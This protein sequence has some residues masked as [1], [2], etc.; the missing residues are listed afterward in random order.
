MKKG[1]SI[2]Y[3]AFRDEV[4]WW[5]GVVGIFSLALVPLTWFYYLFRDTPIKGF[6]ARPFLASDVEVLNGVITPLR[7]ICFLLTLALLSY[8][9]LA[10][11]LKTN[12][13]AADKLSW[14]RVLQPVLSFLLL[15]LL[16][17]PGPISG[18]ANEYAN[19]SAV[20]FTRTTT[21]NLL[22]RFLMPSLA[23]IL[24]F[25]GNFWFSVFSF[26]CTLLLVLMVWLWFQRNQVPLPWWQLLSLET[27]SFI[28]FQIWSPGYPDVLV[29]LFVVAAFTFNLDGRAKAS[30]FA[31]SL[32]THEFSLIL[33][34]GL[35]WILFSGKEYL[36]FLLVGGVYVGLWVFTQQRLQVLFFRGLINNPG[37]EIVGIF[38][39]FKLLWVL[40]IAAMGYLVSQKHSK[41]ALQIGLIFCPESG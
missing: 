10:G 19:S 37:R 39:S 21:L 23:N 36:R 32:A 16:V 22:Q 13:Q 18:Y 28:Y 8:P 25:R 17:F 24:F 15:C 2:T 31:F 38:F 34:L 30:L 41:E 7:G 26:L 6:F 40:V 3:T 29:N 12:R 9:V 27:A 33:W 5:G 11:I 14:P 4:L 35:V 20:F 1:W